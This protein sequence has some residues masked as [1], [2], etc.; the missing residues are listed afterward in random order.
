VLPRYVDISITVKRIQLECQIP[1]ARTL[2]VII[3]RRSNGEGVV[4]VGA[5]IHVVGDWL[6]LF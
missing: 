6:T 5:K 2:L 1:C 4:P 3:V